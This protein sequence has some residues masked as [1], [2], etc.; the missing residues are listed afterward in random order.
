[1]TG[2]HYLG[3]FAG[4]ASQLP[5]VQRVPRGLRENSGPKF[6]NDAL[7]LIRH[8]KPVYIVTS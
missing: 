5:G 1:V 3:D 7:P 2:A 8:T 4:Q 6:D